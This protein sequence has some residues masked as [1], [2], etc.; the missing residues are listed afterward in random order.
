MYICSTYVIYTDR[1][2]KLSRLE[3]KEIV[4]TEHFNSSSP[5]STRMRTNFDLGM[6]WDFH[7]R[8]GTL[9]L[10]LKSLWY[11]EVSTSAFS[12]LL[13]KERE[14]FTL[15]CN[16]IFSRE[17]KGRALPWN[18][19]KWLWR[20]KSLISLEQCTIFIFQHVCYSII[21]ARTMQKYEHVLGELSPKKKIHIFL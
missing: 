5:Q 1:N 8:R 15:K 19:R 6:W 21:T 2:V 14:N 3:N 16:Q 13:S 7:Q 12:F 10:W 20:D 11:R 17:W 18:M 4:P 9:K